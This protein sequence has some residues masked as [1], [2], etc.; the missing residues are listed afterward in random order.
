MG[1]FGCLLVS[2]VLIGEVAER[3][4]SERYDFRL[5]RRKFALI[6]YDEGGK[7]RVTRPRLRS[8]DDIYAHEPVRESKAHQITRTFG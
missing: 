1:S 4:R 2:R 5:E 8:I 7:R 3:Y 6:G